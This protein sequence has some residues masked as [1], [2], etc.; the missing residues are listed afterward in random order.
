MSEAAEHASMA[1]RIQD[2]IHEYKGSSSSSD[3]EE[4]DSLVSR[5]AQRK[6]LFGRKQPVHAVFGGGKVADMIMW[7]NKQVSGGI[8]A[9]VTVV[10]LLFEC[11]DYHLLTF[12]CHAF[13]FVLAA[14]FLWSNA[15]SLVNRSPPK[16]PEV[17]LREDQVLSIAR[18]VRHEINE[19][20]TTF[21]Y[22]ASGKDLKK[23]LMAVG[24]LWVVSVIGNWF[25]FLT[26]CYLVFL[27]LCTLPA[28]YEKYEDQ[29]DDVGETVMVQVRKQHAVLDAKVLQKI[30]RGP[31]ADKKQH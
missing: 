18:S 30:P 17:I 6:R 12:V 14:L 23:F 4:E 24:G 8:L 15:A 20:F 3:S 7:R 27:A 16:F 11:M 21:R 26:L 2:K 29:V 22:I 28:L 19:A 9:V 13:M 5:N 10:W 25:S 1:D 31:F